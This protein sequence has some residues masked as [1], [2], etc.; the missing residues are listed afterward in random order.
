MENWIS[1]FRV[2]LILLFYAESVLTSFIL[3]DN[4]PTSFN[5]MAEEEDI[6]D[7]VD[8]QL[9]GMGSCESPMA[10][11]EAAQTGESMGQLTSQSAALA[12]PHPAQLIAPEII[13]PVVVHQTLL[14]GAPMP[15]AGSATREAKGSRRCA[16]CVEAICG[17]R[18][19]CKGSGG[20]KWCICGHPPL[21]KSRASDRSERRTLQRE[22]A[23][24]ARRG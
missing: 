4:I 5:P 14:P 7:G 2:G 11:E 21:T 19:E 17:K 9:S 1:L 15:T 22:S 10:S 16:L 13:R 18:K 24:E 6:G 8:L 3:G 12:P 20:K 23:A